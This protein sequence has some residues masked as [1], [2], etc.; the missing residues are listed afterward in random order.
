MKK[1]FEY[2]TYNVNKSFWLGHINTDELTQHINYL[3][4]IGWEMVGVIETNKSQG[5]TNE[6]ILLFKR[7]I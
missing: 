3:G 6:V 5:G 1:R 7:E 4:N 2:T